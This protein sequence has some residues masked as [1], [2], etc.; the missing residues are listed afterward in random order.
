LK[1]SRVRA[2]SV[3]LA[4]ALHAAILVG[5]G[6]VRVDLVQDT[7]T[8]WGDG[9]VE[10]ALADRAETPVTI[11]EPPRVR[12]DLPAV[13]RE[14]VE[15]LVHLGGAAAE[16]DEDDF[17]LPEGGAPPPAPSIAVDG[18]PRGGP[19]ARQKLAKHGA[20]IG[21]RIGRGRRGATGAGDG[22]AL[23]A[24]AASPPPPVP[25]PALVVE[26]PPREPVRVAARVVSYEEPR[27]PLAA[28]ERQIEG[29][30]RLEAEVL[31]DASVGDVHVLVSSGSR[32]LDEAAVAAVRR[33]TFAP[34]TVDGVAVASVLAL[35]AIR[36]RMQ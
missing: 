20:P 21:G 12:H 24:D 18:G 1:G 11:A 3:A 19:P 34:A 32:L 7:S 25:P 36:F 4:A 15:D 22:V 14:A 8:P 33:W 27:Y 30:V 2:L 29:V 5:A 35:P 13:P 6:F 9:R 17:T 26:P 23:H 16:G 28:R 31:A 10:L